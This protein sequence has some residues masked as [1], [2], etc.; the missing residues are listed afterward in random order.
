MEVYIKFVTT[1][2]SPWGHRESRHDL[3][4]KQQQ[5]QQQMHEGRLWCKISTNMY[6]LNQR[7]RMNCYILKRKN[8]HIEPNK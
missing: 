1:D 4:I 3:E 7:K 8:C 5:L 6:N 2:Y